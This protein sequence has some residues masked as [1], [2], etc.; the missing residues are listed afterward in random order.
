MAMVT[1]KVNYYGVML[2]DS[3]AKEAGETISETRKNQK[4]VTTSKSIKE[5]TLYPK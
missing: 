3:A 1:E 4:A 2:S 5:G